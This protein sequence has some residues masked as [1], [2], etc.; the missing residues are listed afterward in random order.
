[1]NK[2]GYLDTK[3]ILNTYIGIRLVF[4]KLKWLLIISFIFFEYKITE[5]HQ[6]HFYSGNICLIII[7]III[8]L[9]PL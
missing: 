5:Y 3:I 2:A 4:V 8:G 9:P 1:M 6:I 7:I